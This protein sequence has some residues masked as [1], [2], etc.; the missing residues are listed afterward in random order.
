MADENKVKDIQAS[1]QIIAERSRQI[2]ASSAQ[3]DTVGGVSKLPRAD[4]RP[5]RPKWVFLTANSTEDNFCR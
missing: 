3:L 2:Y 4:K 1:R 5:R